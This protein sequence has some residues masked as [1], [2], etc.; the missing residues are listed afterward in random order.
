[1]YGFLFFSGRSVIHDTG[2]TWYLQNASKANGMWP[3]LSH[4][5]AIHFVLLVSLLSPSSLL[6][7][8]AYVIHSS[9]HHQ[10]LPFVYY[11]IFVVM[12]WQEKA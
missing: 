8:P 3:F 10:F 2:D 9:F 7:T 12:G 11:L 4:V 5:S 1:M 6:Q